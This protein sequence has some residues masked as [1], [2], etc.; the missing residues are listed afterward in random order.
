MNP[1]LAKLQPYPFEKLRQLTQS[2]QVPD[3]PAIA[4]SIGEP[5]HAAPDFLHE[6]LMSHLGGYSNYPATSG[7]PELKDAIQN[8]VRRRF[9]PI[10]PTALSASKH[11]LPVSG[12]REA[13]FSVVQALLDPNKSNNQV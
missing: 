11:V 1:N 6:T 12:T 5:K 8:W 7:T 2:V 4:W 3:L 10:S 13:L 9:L